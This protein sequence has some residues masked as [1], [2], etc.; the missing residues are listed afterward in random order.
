M[1]VRAGGIRTLM[2]SA[3]LHVAETEDGGWDCW[4][5][6]YKIHVVGG[7]EIGKITGVCDRA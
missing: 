2:S 6:I 1:G 4:G 3:R 7:W 5:K